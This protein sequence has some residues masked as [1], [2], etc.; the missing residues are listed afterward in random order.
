MDCHDI[1]EIIN[2]NIL[3]KRNF[4]KSKKV[5]EH[6]ALNKYVISC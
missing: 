2:K 4:A 3:V 6:E 1:F 5:T